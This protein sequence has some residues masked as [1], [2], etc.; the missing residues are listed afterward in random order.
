MY[1]NFATQK[2]LYNEQW[3]KVLLG[4][5]KL[6]IGDFYSPILRIDYFS[7]FETLLDL[8]PSVEPTVILGD[9]NTCL[10][11]HDSRS[12]R[13]RP[14]V[15]SNNLNILP[16]SSTYHFPCCQHLLDLAIASSDLVSA[17]GVDSLRVSFAG[18]WT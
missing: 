18:S 8:V 3:V 1:N 10:L 4:L 9:V 13:L 12:T 16:F 15:D 6:L 17:Y 5:Q 2:I 11:N 7:K 14:I